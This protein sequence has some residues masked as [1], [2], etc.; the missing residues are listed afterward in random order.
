MALR[1]DQVRNSFPTAVSQLARL[2]RRALDVELQPLGM[3]EATWLALL[4]VSRAKEPLR[5]KD[6]ALSLGLDS[7]SV[8]RLLDLL[9]TAA[10]IERQEGADRR[11][12]TIT[13]TPRGKV[14]VA[15]VEKVA[16]DARRRLLSVIPAAELEAALAVIVR[17]SEAVSESIEASV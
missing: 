8:V 9:Q 7:S 1:P 3:T 16:I 4:H 14:V 10:Y 11:A 13:L 2:W 12:K 5:Q 15:Q 17:I 6:L